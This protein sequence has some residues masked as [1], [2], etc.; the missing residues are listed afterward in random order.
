[1]STLVFIHESEHIEA[2]KNFVSGLSEKER[3][4]LTI[5][6]LDAELEP[7]LAKEGVPFVSARGHRTHDDSVML[8]AEQWTGSIF[9]SRRW[10]FFA[11]RTVALGQLFFLTLQSYLLNLLHYSDIIANV[12]ADMP[13]T[14]LIVFAPASTGPARGSTLVRH[15]LRAVVDAVQTIGK[16]RGQEVQ[17]IESPKAPMLSGAKWSFTVQRAM[18]GAGLMLLNTAV[19]IIRPPRRVR[20]LASDYWSNV[21]LYIKHVESVEV[22]LLD[23]KEAL[24]A[25]FRNIWKFRMRFLH[26]DASSLR[27]SGERTKMQEFFAVE[28]QAIK[29][30]HDEE[31]YTFR[32]ISMRPLV[33]QALDTIVQTATHETLGD[34][35][36]AH[37]LLERMRPDL[38]ILRSTISAQPHFFILAHVARAQGIPSLEMQHGLEYYGPGSTDRRH[39]AEYMGVYG[40]LTKKEMEEA[41][42]KQVVPVVIGSPRFDVYA[43]TPAIK[44]EEVGLSVLCIAPAM[45]PG[46]FSSYDVLD[47]FDAVAGAV[48]KVP[49]ASV[50]I[51]L[52]PGLS[53]DPF[54][55]ATFESAFAGIPHS[56]AKREPLWE[57][58]PKTDIVVTHYSTTALEALMC[59]KPLVYLGLSPA[60]RTMGEYQFKPYTDAGVMRMASSAE[61][62]VQTLAGLAAEDGTRERMGKNA[63]AFLERE[64]AFDGNASK[65]TAELICTLTQC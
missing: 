51:K 43:S 65:R 57:L 49:G 54:Q 63:A 55:L 52:R 24:R 4:A 44:R 39:S 18:F 32:G 10:S 2:L 15:Q 22:L 29:A 25:G 37:V 42:D 59:Q 30:A 27:S 5:V 23:R 45:F 20:I 31:Q 26:L 1:M 62:L 34:I 36:A 17:V 28:W 50:V 41:G 38:V 35:D 40:P 8:L 21:S 19:T 33:M 53:R 7:M 3:K 60:Q 46:L 11:Y 64:Y 6:A 12:T 47:Y 13:A 9:N 61:E 58:Y 48:R 14:R 56:I 16:Q